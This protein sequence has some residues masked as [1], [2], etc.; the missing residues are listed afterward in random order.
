MSRNNF[1][2]LVFTSLF[3]AALAT[4]LLAEPAQAQNTADLHRPNPAPG[5]SSNL[6]KAPVSVRA[7]AGLAKS[8]APPPATTDTWQGGPSFATDLIPATP[9]Q[10]SAAIDRYAPCP[11]GSGEK[12]KFCCGEKG[13]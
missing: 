2:S 1:V 11:C 3:C 8:N 5:S 4:G 9:P 12:Y 13:R 7:K 6:S 10:P